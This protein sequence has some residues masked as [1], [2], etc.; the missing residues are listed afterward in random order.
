MQA[1]AMG[2]VYQTGR[3]QVAPSRAFVA[4]VA[5]DETGQFRFGDWY[6]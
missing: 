3:A 2:W 5:M 4:V 1:A 6:E